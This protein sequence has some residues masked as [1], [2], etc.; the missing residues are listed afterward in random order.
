MERSARNVWSPS[1]NRKSY[2]TFASPYRYFTAKG[3]CPR[4]HAFKINKESLKLWPKTKKR[5]KNEVK[6]AKQ[7]DFY[8]YKNCLKI[9]NGGRLA[10]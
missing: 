9:G 3:R 5:S 2:A 8:L 4:C 7:A 10:I 1:S 6:K